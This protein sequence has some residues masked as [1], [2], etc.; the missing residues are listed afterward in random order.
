MD[1]KSSCKFLIDIG[2]GKIVEDWLQ[3]E[4]FCIISVRSLNPAMKDSEILKLAADN[5]CMIITMDKDF[6]EL[7]Y[8]SAKKHSGILIL[9]LESATG[10]EKLDV[11][12]E[13][14]TNYIDKIYNHFCVYQK[15]KLRIRVEK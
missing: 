15:G 14:F 12:K 13:I 11:M 1:N 2:V 4:G 3:S 7:V 10:K 8:H 5:A 6:G 9:R